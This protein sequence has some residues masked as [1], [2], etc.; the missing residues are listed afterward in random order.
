MSLHAALILMS[1]DIT[2]EPKV[3]FRKGESSLKITLVPSAAS[4]ASPKPINNTQKNVLKVEDK[5]LKGPMPLQKPEPVTVT[6]PVN[7]REK[8]VLR[9]EE[10]TLDS[11]KPVKNPKI[12]IE[13][14]VKVEDDIV[15]KTKE[16]AYSTQYFKSETKIKDQQRQKQ[17]MTTDNSKEIIADVKAKG[18][19]T[20]AMVENV[21]KP[22]YPS[23]CK[24]Q[25]HEGST[26]LEVT[27]LSNGKRGNIEII[28]SA[29]CESLDKAAINALKKAKYIPAKRIGVPFT[30]KK[31][32]V[33]NFKLEDS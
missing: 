27:I 24:R 12:P 19:T 28:Q 8:H 13:K 17:K 15:R 22:S 6:K 18:V 30:A 5:K 7:K 3:M 1:P 33:F 29:G 10:K 32:I 20:G 11:P 14:Q 23:R 4:T 31:K 26:L 16:T 21:F 2:S 25:G 9:M